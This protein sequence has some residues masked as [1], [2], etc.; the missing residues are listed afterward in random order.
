MKGISVIIP[1]LN[2]AENLSRLLPHLKRHVK[3]L[4]SEIIVIEAGECA[5]TRE[6]CAL[7]QVIH[8]KTEI[9]SRA[10]QMNRGAKEANYDV[11]YFVHADTLPPETFY[12][13]IDRALSKG[14]NAGCYRFKFD[15]DVFPL[16]LNS[17]FT[18]FK[19]QMFR[20]GDQS[21]F[22][23]RTFFNQLDG[24]DEKYRLM[25]E[26]PFIKKLKSKGQFCVM[27]RSIIV[28]SRKYAGNS[29]FKVNMVNFLVFALFH[30]GLSSNNLKRIYHSLLQIPGA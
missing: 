11:L 12:K 1:A 27:S 2:E 28:S 18:R 14:F 9:S 19:P 10:V 8:I 16:M 3:H 7:N 22:V 26:Y 20:G 30:L 21:L 23:D 5:K 17:F 24:F 15:R 6:L 4:P 25:E 13:D 29:Y